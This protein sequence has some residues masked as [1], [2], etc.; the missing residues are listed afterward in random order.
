M[1]RVVSGLKLGAN[2][3]KKGRKNNIFKTPPPMRHKP[4]DCQVSES[5][6]K[7]R[8]ATGVRGSADEGPVAKKNGGGGREVGR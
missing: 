7:R 3:T 6:N 1:S 8:R 2:V 5:H 4:P